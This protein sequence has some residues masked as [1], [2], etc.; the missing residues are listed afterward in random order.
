MPE[1]APKP[2]NGDKVGDFMKDEHRRHSP[3]AT[4]TSGSG[5]SSRSDS[6]DTWKAPSFLASTPDSNE[7]ENE[8]ASSDDHRHME[9]QQYE[10]QPELPGNDGAS[11][12]SNISQPNLVVQDTGKQ[13]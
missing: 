1:N 6:P 5:S 3:H 8:N 13:I 9:V 4:D 10:D 7:E 12:G 2:E 11:P